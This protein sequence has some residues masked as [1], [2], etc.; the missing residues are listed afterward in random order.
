MAFHFKKRESPTKAVR[1]LGRERIGKAL[2]HLRK[3]DRLEAIHNVRK[4]VKKVRA[5]LGLVRE[6]TGGDTARK[7][8]KNLRAAGRLLRDARHPR[9]TSIPSALMGEMAV[10]RCRPIRC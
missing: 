7:S 3:C 2:D 10:A 5:V 4:E 6:A 9:S 8:V 1:R